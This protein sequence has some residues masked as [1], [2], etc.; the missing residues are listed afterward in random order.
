MVTYSMVKDQPYLFISVEVD[1]QEE[2]ALLTY[3]LP[4]GYMGLT[5]RFGTPFGSIDRRS[6]GG[7]AEKEAMWE[8][9]ASRWLAVHDGMHRGLALLSADIYGCSVHDGTV[10]LSLLRSPCSADEQGIKGEK[11]FAEKSLHSFEFAVGPYYAETDQD[12]LS[13]AQASDT[14]FL[15]PLYLSARKAFPP[16]KLQKAGTLV[17]SW[18]KPAMTRQGYILR[19]HEAAGTSGE[20]IIELGEG[21]AAEALLVDLLERPRRSLEISDKRVQLRYSAYELLSLLIVKKT[22][23]PR[24]PTLPASPLPGT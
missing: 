21:P 5:S 1:W 19:L 22:N 17:I 2:H 23:R 20:A 8:L 7:P 15:P 3:E 12:H 13:T 16:F 14:L 6:A 4:T 11:L 10:E 9:P 24:L 18:I